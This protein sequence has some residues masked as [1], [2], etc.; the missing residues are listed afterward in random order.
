M[1]K[2]ALREGLKSGVTSEATAN[3]LLCDTIYVR[4]V[5]NIHGVET[6]RSPQYLA[7]SFFKVSR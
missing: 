7:T 4:H 3:L 6:P 2:G 1:L 5:Y